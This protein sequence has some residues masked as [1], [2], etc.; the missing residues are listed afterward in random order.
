MNAFY[1]SLNDP[2]VKALHEWTSANAEAQL[3]HYQDVV[4]SSVIDENVDALILSAAPRDLI[5][6]VDPET[7][8][9]VNLYTLI[10]RFKAT[11]NK[12]QKGMNSNADND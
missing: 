2:F 7:K 11:V 9:T 10:N 4:L 6:K 3:K 1:D 8:Q 5:G 12:Y